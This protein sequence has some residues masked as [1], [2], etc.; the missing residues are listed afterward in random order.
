MGR[1]TDALDRVVD[2]A[3]KY[4][5]GASALFG[6]IG[7]VGMPHVPAEAVPWA[8]LAGGFIIYAA[9]LSVGRK[10]GEESGEAKERA[11]L[12]RQA[13]LEE[14]RI[15]AEAKAE[16]E[17]ARAL[18]EIED[19]RAREERE[20][21]ETATREKR[22]RAEEES[23]RRAE[24]RVRD[25]ANNVRHLNHPSKYNLYSLLVDGP[26]E[27]PYYTIRYGSATVSGI[28]ETFNDLMR[29]GLTEYEVCAGNSDFDEVR[30]WMPT[31]LAR[32]VFEKYPEVFSDAEREYR[33]SDNGGEQLV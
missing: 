28:S 21:E 30:R 33:C 22:A 32:E 18:A 20:R 2:A 19:R 9:G 26:V 5:I 25:V 31:N 3:G 27:V 8:S 24:A 29:L 1:L 4:W 23:R 13:S 16:I 17:K 12:E 10:V 15:A 11:R 14:T 6:I 7:A